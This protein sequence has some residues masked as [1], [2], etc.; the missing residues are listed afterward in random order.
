M[1][2]LRTSPSEPVYK[3]F[4]KRILRV[5][6]AAKRLCPVDTGRLRAS[7]RWRILPQT[8]QLLGFVGTDTN[9]ALFVHNGTSGG[10]IITPK[11]KQA[12]FWPGAE[13]P[14]GSVVRGATHAQPFL[15]EALPAAAG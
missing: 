1:V 7:I 15:S 9:Y 11:N 6:A 8:H 3:D 12:L 14:V 10:Q 4:L 13:H 2:A 5:D